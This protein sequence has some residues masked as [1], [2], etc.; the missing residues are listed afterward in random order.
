MAIQVITL[1]QFSD[2]ALCSLAMN[3]DRQIDYPA[4]NWS[5]AIPGGKPSPQPP[6]PPSVSIYIYVCV[7]EHPL[8]RV[9]AWLTEIEGS[10]TG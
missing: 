9:L 5:V 4:L 7:T 8:F 3:C 10:S 2:K 1:T 6:K